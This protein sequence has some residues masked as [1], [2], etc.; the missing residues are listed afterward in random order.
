VKNA[1][2]SRPWIETPDAWVTTGEAVDPAEALR[3]AA[4]EM[5][6]L[7][8]RE[9]ALNFEEA[10]MLMSARADVQVCQIC[11]PGSFPITTRAVFPRLTGG[12]R[13]G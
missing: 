11:E 9:L 4:Q 13:T 6:D 1:P 12:D 8:Q 10:Y 5:A 7:L 3:I 2:V